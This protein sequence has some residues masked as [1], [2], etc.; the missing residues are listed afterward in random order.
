MPENTTVQ[1]RA[2]TASNLPVPVTPEFRM[3]VRGYDRDE[4]DAYIAR[5]RSEIDDH[6]SPSGAVRR[7]LEQVGDEVAGILQRAHDTAAEVTSTAQREAEDRLAAS[8]REA[9]DRLAASRREAEDRIAE[10][11]VTAAAMTAQAEAKLGELDLDTDRIWAERD[12]IVQ[13]ARDLARQLLG[14]ADA[15]AER[16]PPAEPADEEITAVLVD[17]GEEVTLAGDPAANGH[18]IGPYVAGGDDDEDQLAEAD[19]AD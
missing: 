4:V 8:R 14:L 7:A 5:L 6:R 15:A 1:L 12:R 13:D 11:R 17:E 18:V 9:E 16:F 10:S 19:A 3:V 2:A